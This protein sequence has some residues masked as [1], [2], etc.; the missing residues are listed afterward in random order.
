[1]ETFLTWLKANWPTISFYA[2][3]ALILGVYFWKKWRAEKQ[4]FIRRLVDEALAFVRELAKQAQTE[5]DRE[6]VAEVVGG[7]YDAFVARTGF[8]RLITRDGLIELAWQAWQQYVRVEATVQV[9]ARAVRAR[10]AR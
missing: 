9:R 6:D 8:A 10:K 2:I 1:M 3:V 5:I 7:F 4:E